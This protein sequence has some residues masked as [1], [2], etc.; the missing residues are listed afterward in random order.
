MAAHSMIRGS[1]Y[2][3][4]VLSISLL[5]SGCSIFSG[6]TKLHKT[7]KASV[8]TK[9]I[10]DWSFEA[11]HPATID[12]VTM[13]RIIK[14][15]VSDDSGKTSA[16]MPASGSKPMRV[17]SDEDAEFLAPLLAQALS[18][19]KPEQ[20]VGF[21]VS[22][23]AGSGAEPTAGTLYM[24]RGSL[25]FTMASSQ[26]KKAWG[27]SPS[28]F[29]R[30]EKAPSFVPFGSGAVTLVI[31]YQA[32]AKAPQQSPVTMAGS[33]KGQAPA[34]SAAS[35]SIVAT[36]S[37]P[38]PQSESAASQQDKD[39]LRP[40][41][42]SEADRSLDPTLAELASDQLLNK[43]MDELR[44]VREVNKIKDSE[45]SMLKKE[46]KLMKQE[47]RDRTAEVNALK[48]DKVSNR[49][50]LKKKKAQVSPTP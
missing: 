43:K 7:A 27:F 17:F 32:V 31:D 23:S 11:H 30:A 20:M 39:G 18:K 34:Q 40:S 46:V 25:Y 19:A 15:I 29:A 10:A 41:P 48:A 49:L 5:V 12:Q 13:L 4:T 42:I 44:E 14:G 22:S 3:G 6:E 8:Y 33:S 37:A 47:L 1:H 9:E 50:P 45:I 28:S 26:G 36:A 2:L 21:K 38:A 16:N 24:Y 35:A